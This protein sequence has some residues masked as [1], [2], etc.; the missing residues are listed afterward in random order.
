MSENLVFSEIVGSTSAHYRVIDAER[1]RARHFQPF[2]SRDSALSTGQ[3]K[4]KK[5]SVIADESFR[6]FRPHRLRAVPT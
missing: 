1:I 3:R 6:G 2:T 5:H 4:F